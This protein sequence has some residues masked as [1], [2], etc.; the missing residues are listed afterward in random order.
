M[1][2]SEAFD[3]YY[4]SLYPERWAELRQALLQP[5][6]HIARVTSVGVRSGSGENLSEVYP[7]CLDPEHPE[8]Q[9]LM[10]EQEGHCYAMDLASVLAARSLDVQSGMQVWDA[11]A[12]PGGKTL[13]L[14][15]A[16]KGEGSLCACDLSR[17][18]CARLK[19]VVA[20]HTV[21]PIASPLKIVSCDS[22]NWGY[23]HQNTYD[24]VMLDAPCSSERHV[25]TDDTHL[26]RWSEKRVKTL[27][28]RQYALLC[29]AV[30]AC[31]PGGRIVY[32][33]CSINPAE[34]DGIIERYMQKKPDTIGC[35][36]PEVPL[37]RATTYGWSIT[38]DLDD[39]WG[40]LYFTVIRKES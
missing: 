37:G 24:A 22:V 19:Q 21:D 18:R 10:Q 29:S 9:K 28:K 13:I 8:V 5:K 38:P 30:L 26:N 33:T 14:L 4:R 40:P 2:P 15:E 20:T 32:S 3:A 27:L 23:R 31:R 16:L 12:A 1:Q 25:I 7:G 6:R 36:E 34:N 35:E 17:A 39:G 11:C